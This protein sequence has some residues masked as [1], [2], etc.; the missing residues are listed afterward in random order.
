MP[1]KVLDSTGSG[2]TSTI[3][4]GIVWAADHGAQT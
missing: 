2:K 3:A 4:A 1:V